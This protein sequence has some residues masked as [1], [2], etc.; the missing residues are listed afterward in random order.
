MRGFFKVLGYEIICYYFKEIE[1]KKSVYF[2]I[3]D[4]FLSIALWFGLYII[5]NIV[6]LVNLEVGKIQV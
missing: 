1:V 2:C 5:I 4:F 3:V 6:I